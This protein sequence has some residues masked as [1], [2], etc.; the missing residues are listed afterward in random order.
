M[1]TLADK[2]SEHGRAYLKVPSLCVVERAAGLC[3]G[4]SGIVEWRQDG[5]WISGSL[6]VQGNRLVAICQIA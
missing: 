2:A 1:M 4:A 3:A 6:V 5:L